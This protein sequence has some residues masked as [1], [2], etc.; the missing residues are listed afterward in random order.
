VTPEVLKNAPT[1]LSWGTIP[2]SKATPLQSKAELFNICTRATAKIDNFCNTSLRGQ[3]FTEVFVG[4]GNLRFAVRPNGVVK[5]IPSNPPAMQ[6]QSASYRSSTNYPP[7]WSTIAANLFEV[8]QFGRYGSDGYPSILMAPGYVGWQA[9]RY[10]YS[11]KLTYLAGWPHTATIAAATVGATTIRV[12]DISGWSFIASGM[13]RDPTATEGIAV[14]AV[15]PDVAGA[16]SGS[17]TLTLASPLTYAHGTGVM[18]SSLPEDVVDAAI[19]YACAD[20]LRRGTASISIQSM[21]MGGGGGAGD[22]ES[23]ELAAEDV[24]DSYRRVL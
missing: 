24:L 7:V 5:F 15:T 17:G 20:A 4:P 2:N 23:Y 14:A 6:V 1:G 16:L 22:I 3:L 13:L 19:N 8:E 18:L 12:N 11:V 10:G 9:G 21:H